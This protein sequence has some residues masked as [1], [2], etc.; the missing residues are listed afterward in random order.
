MRAFGR[1][2]SLDYMSWEYEAER[3]ERPARGEQRRD[4]G[5]IELE[6]R[7]AVRAAAAELFAERGPLGV[8]RRQA[9]DAARV[10]VSAAE[11]LYGSE[12][13][14]LGDVLADF[15]H[16]LVMAVCVAFDRGED[17]G[18]ADRLE[19]VIRAWL[20]HVAGHRA[21]NRAFLLG[22]PQ[23]G[24]PYKAQVTSKYRTAL[25]TV[26]EALVKV[27][28]E[29]DVASDGLVEMMRALLSDVWCWPDGSGVE[30]RGAAARRIAGV[31]TAA[32]TAE[33]RGTWAG[34]GPAAGMGD[35]G[36]RVLD[37]TQARKR[38]SGVLDYVALGAR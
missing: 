16:G 38:F 19:A 15:A 4:P 7:A 3:R 10:P 30:G 37:Y 8:T 35:V 9:G 13:E 18:P 33:A 36:P 20:D 14:L 11:R 22:L 34:F 32:A 6:R 5:E 29:F 17:F 26:A 1:P 24:E 25:D 27:V 28:P 12:A 2:G 23:A 31:L 21:A